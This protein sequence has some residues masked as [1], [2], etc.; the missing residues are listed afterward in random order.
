M[1]SL[2]KRLEDREREIRELR[3]QLAEAQEM[4]R[5]IHEGEVDALVVST[6][7]G[8]RIFTLQGAD[9]TYRTIV[10]QM[11][12]GAVTL[13]QAGRVSYSNRRFA[14]IVKRPLEQ[15]IGAYFGDFVAEPHKGDFDYLVIQALRGSARGE[16]SLQAADG[17][18][19]PV[20]L[21]LSLLVLDGQSSLCMVVTDL[22]ERKRAEAV[23]ANEQFVRRL[24]QSAPIGVA[25]VGR[26]LRSGRLR[27]TG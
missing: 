26:D 20:H 23:L 18:A 10:E 22:T 5:A 27:H 25:V 24:I 19:V 11:Q 14:E 13:I 2:E 17:A 16:V 12:E 9:Q 4:L 7:E 21:G 8:P 6:P 1:E 3:A 15:I